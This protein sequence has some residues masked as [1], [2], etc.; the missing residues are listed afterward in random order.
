M[1]DDRPLTVVVPAHGPAA[2]VEPLLVELGSQAL[3]PGRAP[4]RVVVSDDASPRP[5]GRDL[6]A[7]A[8]LDLEVVRSDVNG[9]PGAARNRGLALVDT[10]WVAFLDA[11]TVPGSGWLARA[12]QAVA[13]DEAADLLEGRTRIPADQPPSPFTH[14]TEATP[15]DQHVAG[16]VVFRTSVLRDAGGFDERYYDPERH[17]HF[18]EDAELAFR[19]EAAGATMAYDPELVVDHP[20]LPSTFWGPVRLARRYHFDALL[21]REHPEA[22][23]AMNGRRRIGPISLRKARHLASLAVVLGTLLALV[24]LLLQVAG[25][26]AWW[27]VGIGALLALVGWAAT[28]VA[29]CWRRRV[30]VVH[31]VPV[32]VVAAF[33]PWAYVWHWARG[34]VRFRHRPRF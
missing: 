15:P 13:A 20:P 22:F 12:E 19:L 18:R 4:L 1:N 5:L 6:V 7:A 28:T 31:L 23:R 32:V 26:R 16:N 2:Q 3:A 14:A 27:V 33:V 29:L 34:V 11:D 17:L 9:G 30:A 24:G 21:D 25:A 8:G 10:P